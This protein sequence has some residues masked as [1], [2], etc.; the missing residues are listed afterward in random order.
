MTTNINQVKESL[1]KEVALKRKFHSNSVQRL[2]SYF[3]EHS[4]IK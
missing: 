1:P 2:I 3:Y 4:N